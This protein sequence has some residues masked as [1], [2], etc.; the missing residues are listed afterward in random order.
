MNEF[1]YFIFF[2]LPSTV[3]HEN[4]QLFYRQKNDILTILQNN[5][6]LLFNILILVIYY[7]YILFSIERF[8]WSFF[9]VV[10]IYIRVVQYQNLFFS[11]YLSFSRFIR[12]PILKINLAF[13]FLS[14]CLQLINYEQNTLMTS[15]FSCRRQPFIK[16]PDVISVNL[17]HYFF[18]S[19]KKDLFLNLFVND[20][21]F[22][23][24][25]K[26]L[27]DE[28]HF[29]RCLSYYNSTIFN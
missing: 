13:Q 27:L 3:I 5:I 7:T 10:H 2:F 11:S 1:I 12:K 18:S 8:F 19:N 16:I 17:N 6:F 25:Q 4:S 20:V 28:F 23:N 15:Q 29:E 21:N 26:N 22:N 14:S 24:S 9:F